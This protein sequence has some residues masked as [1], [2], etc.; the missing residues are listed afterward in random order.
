VV[1]LSA[2]ERALLERWARRPKSAQA[3][4]QR[5]RIVLACAAGET[6]QGVAER[7]GVSVPTVRKWRGRF[8]VDRL[9]G[10]VDEPRPGRP[11][12]VTDDQVE[13][14]IV[15]TLESAPPDGGTHWSTRQMARASGLSQTTI[16]MVW[17]AF[18]L[19]P[20]RVEHWKLSKDAL[21][22]DKVRD[23]VGLYLDPPERALVLCVDEKSQIQALDRTAPTLPMLPGT[24]KRA[25]HDYKRNGTSSLFA[26]LES[27]LAKLGSLHPA[28]ARS[29]FKK[30]LA[31]RR[32]RPPELDV[33]LILDNYA[34]TRHRRSDAGCSPTPLPA[35]LHAHRREL[36]Q[37]RRALVRRA[38]Q[39]Q[40]QIRHP[41]QR[42]RAQRRHPRLAQPLERE[43]PPLHLDQDRRPDPRNPRLIL[44]TN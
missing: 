8:A 19:Q 1:E 17:R 44:Q 11:R 16:S 35:A 29:E 26:A 31:D 9:E 15:R 3:L 32:A 40:A 37:S 21:F 30:F 38:H 14:V 41:P 7:L 27:S 2:A 39:P 36:A 24:P 23:I 34:P 33:H 20:H 5:S 12:S 13:D 25:T 43:P 18:G 28:T 42:P 10:L 6:N 22:V 4:A